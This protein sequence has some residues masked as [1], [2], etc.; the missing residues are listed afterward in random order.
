MIRFPA[1][2]ELSEQRHLLPA[3]TQGFTLP[4]CIEKALLDPECDQGRWTPEPGRADST[5]PWITL[6][7]DNHLW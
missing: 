1:R 5:F 4:L 6:S 7:L 2:R 3:Y